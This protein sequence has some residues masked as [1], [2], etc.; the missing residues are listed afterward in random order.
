MR[1]AEPCPQEEPL[2]KVLLTMGFKESKL[3]DLHKM[4]G[5]EW[6]LFC[7]VATLSIVFAV[8]FRGQL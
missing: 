6:R 3:K 8:I 5:V 7:R 2:K 1:A 4:G